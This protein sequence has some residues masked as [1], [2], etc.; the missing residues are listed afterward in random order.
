MNILSIAVGAMLCA[1]LPAAPPAAGG[2]AL[3]VPSMPAASLPGTVS[4]ASPV[5]AATFAP[6]PVGTPISVE[7]V[8]DPAALAPNFAPPPAG[9]V[10]PPAGFNDAARGLFES[11]HAF[12]G[13]THAAEQSR[14]VQGPALPHG[15]PVPLH[16][17]LVAAEHAGRSA[18]APS[19]ST[20][21]S[22]GSPSP[23]GSSSSPTR[24][25]WSCSRR[26]GPAPVFGMANI[27]AGAKYVLIRDVEDQFLFS[28]V[29]QYE[30]PTGYSNIF[31]G[32]GNGLLGRLRHPRQGVRRQLALHQHLRPE[33]RAEQLQL[34]L[35]HGHGPPR[36]A[37][38]Q[39]RPVLRGQLVLLQPERHARAG[40]RRRGRRLGEHRCRQRHRPELSSPTPSVSTT[41]STSTSSSASPTSI[42][43]RPAP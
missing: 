42:S 40:P 33:H 11:D 37:V 15:G 41:S 2:R 34:R 43:S 30:A 39:V 9:Y 35:L 23:S 16:G 21:S 27:V 25:G 24:T 36:Q 32:H 1:Q 13:F 6:Q 29:L 31:E 4:S 22:C 18:A 19:R 7:D 10:V 12:D 28:G 26:R 38:R 20:P 14:P 8:Q 5:P 17:Q 3:Q